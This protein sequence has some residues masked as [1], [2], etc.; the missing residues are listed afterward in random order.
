[1]LILGHIILFRFGGV[2]CV[3][4]NTCPRIPWNT[5]EQHGTLVSVPVCGAPGHFGYYG[6]GVG[7]EAE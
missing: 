4:F 1:M 6:G 3:Q 2:R 7:P 5:L